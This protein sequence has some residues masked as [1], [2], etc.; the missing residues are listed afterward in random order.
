MSKPIVLAVMLI[1]APFCDRTARAAEPQQATDKQ[2]AV[3]LLVD[4]ARSYGYQVMMARI[5]LERDRTQ[6]ERDAKLFEQKK[7]L[8]RRK[9]IP[10]LE[11]EI[12]EL[13]DTWN[14]AQLVVAQ[15]NL[16]YV[17]AEYE[18]MVQLARHFGGSSVTAEA[19]YATFRK[20]WDAGCAKGPDEVAAAK[21][22]LDFMVKVV[23]RARQL[24]KER[25]EPLSSL[26]EKEAQ[27]GFA[28]SEYQNRAGSV[29]RCR[30]LL[31]PSLQDI[32][33]VGP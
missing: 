6:F 25:N 18:A 22:R 14:R 24:H 32:Q 16:D 33:A 15:K 10:S 7:E 30:D 28:R 8:H 3:L 5:Q 12:A 4:Y 17:Q 26:L 29:S 31:F 23:D 13:K 21:A 9:V 1:F 2:V 19:L 11:L 27:L 20:G